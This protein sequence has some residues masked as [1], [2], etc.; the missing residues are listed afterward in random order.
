M[1]VLTPGKPVMKVELKSFSYKVCVPAVTLPRGRLAA[2]R[3]AHCYQ[4]AVWGG[5]LELI[6]GDRVASGLLCPG[7]IA[8]YPQPKPQGVPGEH[9]PPG[10]HGFAREFLQVPCLVR[11][12]PGEWGRLP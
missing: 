11:S 12:K 9:S 10:E 4:R 1:V 2:R 7:W 5:H 8:I 3:G 6:M